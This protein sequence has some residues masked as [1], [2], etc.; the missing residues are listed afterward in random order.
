M[1]LYSVSLKK[2]I[3]KCDRD[4]TCQTLKLSFGKAFL[5]ALQRGGQGGSDKTSQAIF[6]ILYEPWV[7]DVDLS[8][9]FLVQI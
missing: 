9:I 2:T 5:A 6:L 7:K 1:G 4:W 8:R 3:S